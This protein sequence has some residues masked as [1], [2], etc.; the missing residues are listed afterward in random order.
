VRQLVDETC[1]G[2]GDDRFSAASQLIP[3]RG[4]NDVAVVGDC[5]KW[6]LN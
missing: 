3:A 1:G 4:E 5:L 2:D 6:I